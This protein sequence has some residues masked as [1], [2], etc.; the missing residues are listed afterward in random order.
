M[1]NLKLDAERT[2]EAVLVGAEELFAVKG[3]EGA[4]LE[5]IGAAAGLSRGTPGYF[6]GSKENL[7][8]AV[9]ERLFARAAAVLAPAHEAV[10]RDSASPREAIELLIGAYLHFL[11]EDPNFVRLIRRETAEGGDWLRTTLVS[12]RAGAHVSRRAR[13][14]PTQQGGTRGPEASDH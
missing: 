7:Y 5:E 4:S 2:R 9:R 13:D 14:R 10:A 1:R 12:L 11:A 6:F 3:Y 8:R